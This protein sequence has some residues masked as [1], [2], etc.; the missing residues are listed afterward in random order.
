[1][2]G[3]VGLGAAARSLEDKRKESLKAMP[4]WWWWLRPLSSSINMD[5]LWAVGAMG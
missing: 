4:V 2:C 3:R 5:T 1:M